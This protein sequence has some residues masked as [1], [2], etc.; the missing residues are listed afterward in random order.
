[1]GIG[2]LIYQDSMEDWIDKSALSSTR[3]K[4]QRQWRTR[5]DSQFKSCGSCMAKSGENEIPIEFDR[6][7]SIHDPKISLVVFITN[8]YPFPDHTIP[9]SHR[10]R[11]THPPQFLSHAACRSMMT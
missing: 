3:E 1:M 7:Q 10:E 6:A 5:I 9:L 8:Y 2:K 11:T 4:I